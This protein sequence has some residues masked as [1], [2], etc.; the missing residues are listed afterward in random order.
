VTYPVQGDSRGK[1]KVLGGDSIGHN[2]SS[3][4]NKNAPRFKEPEISSPLSKEP[5]T[6]TYPEPDQS[7]PRSQRIS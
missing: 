5:A 7:S 6:R 1:V 3:D 4:S 2:T